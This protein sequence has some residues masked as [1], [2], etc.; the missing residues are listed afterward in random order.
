MRKIYFYAI[1]LVFG[2]SAASQT[3][4]VPDANLMLK[5]TT[6][7]CASYAPNPPESGYHNYVDANGDGQIQTSEALNVTALDI[8]TSPYNTTGDIVSL[9]GLQYFT[10]L[11]KLYVRGNQIEN[12][13]VTAFPDLQ[14]LRCDFN[15]LTTLS[16]ANLAQL[17]FL[18]CSSNL[19]TSLQL[20]DLPS[21][22]TLFFINNEITNVTLDLPALKSLQFENNQITSISLDG[23]PSLQTLQGRNNLL[24]SVDL[25][26]LTNLALL[27]LSANPLTELNLSGLAELETLQLTETEI[28]TIDCSLTGINKLVCG[29]NPNLTY[30]NVQNNRTSWGDTDMLDFPFLFHN[31][32]NLEGICID[33][34]EFSWIPGSYDYNPDVTIYTGADC[35]LG[36]DDAAEV[37]TSIWPNPVSNRL[38]IDAAETIVGINVFNALGQTVFSGN[39]NGSEAF[40]ADISHLDTGIYV[41]QVTTSLGKSVHRIVRD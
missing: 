1:V 35:S 29:N 23:L 5:F 40:S 33:A 3:I 4:A 13:D 10:N 12:L 15:N 39:G 34:A 38:N 2:W 32:P 6:E 41:V 27:N 11:K 7:G 8:S 31:L 16:V 26:S 37:R 19:L 36:T 25:Q 28:T 24:T 30:I 9:E 20:S 14:V 22:E 17:E 18:N 21:L